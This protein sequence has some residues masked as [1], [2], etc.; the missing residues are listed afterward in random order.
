MPVL[1]TLF[2]SKIFLIVDVDPNVDTW[3]RERRSR[4]DS[5]KNGERYK[6]QE[7]SE[8]RSVDLVYT[9]GFVLHIIYNEG[10]GR[11]IFS[12]D[13]LRAVIRQVRD[14]P[15]ASSPVPA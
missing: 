1:F 14:R 12:A 15:S 8:A 2:A 7:I 9:S 11:L 5:S 10:G 4:R 13:A 3:R 6:E